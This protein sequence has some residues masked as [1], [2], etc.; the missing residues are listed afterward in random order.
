MIDRMNSLK[1]IKFS[2]LLS[3]LHLT[4]RQ[5]AVHHASQLPIFRFVNRERG[6]MMRNR[7]VIGITVLLMLVFGT[8]LYAQQE[9]GDRGGRPENDQRRA[10]F[11]QFRN[12]MQLMR[13]VRN[14]PELD[15][16]QAHRLNRAQAKQ[17]LEIVQPL[18]SQP[19]LT[20]EKAKA[21][22]EK[23]EKVFTKAQIEVMAKMRPARR[24]GQ[25]GQNGAGGRLGRDNNGGQPGAGRP[26]GNRGGG[27]GGQG[28]RNGGPG[29][30]QGGSRFE[31]DWNPFYAKA[32]LTDDRSKEM[33]KRTE[34]AFTEL[35]NR[36]AG[37]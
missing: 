20:P 11:G 33:A 12:T 25:G 31:K 15:K 9:G 1:F 17:I 8:V 35:K 13:T 2:E 24:G 28:G 6:R 22:L 5:L 34:A 32:P 3:I 27:N 16:D 29:G 7:L 36:A 26:Q 18:R 37:K 19:K 23:V 10:M 4:R 14:I 30:R 21:V